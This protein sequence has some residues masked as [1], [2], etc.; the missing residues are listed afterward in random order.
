VAV[1]AVIARQRG[2]SDLAEDRHQPGGEQDSD[3]PA[4][5]RQQQAFRQ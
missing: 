5:H 4:E 1:I 3:A 2:R